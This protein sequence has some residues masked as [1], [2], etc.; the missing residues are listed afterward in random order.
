M[1]LSGLCTWS[2]NLNMEKLKKNKKNNDF[3]KNQLLKYK[4]KRN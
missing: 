3:L 1:S 4:Y 2:P